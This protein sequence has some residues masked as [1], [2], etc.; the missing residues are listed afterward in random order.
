MHYNNYHLQHTTS[1]SYKVFF[2]NNSPRPGFVKKKVEFSRTHS[3]QKPIGWEDENN[4]LFIGKTLI[5]K[6]NIIG[7]VTVCIDI[8]NDVC[9]LISNKC[10]QFQEIFILA[11]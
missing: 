8:S 4:S 2:L 9:S 6:I 10:P 1:Y 3:I 11:R 7:R 5:L